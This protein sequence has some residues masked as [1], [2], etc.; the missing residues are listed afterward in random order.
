M[1]EGQSSD[2]VNQDMGAQSGLVD[3]ESDEVGMKCTRR[4]GV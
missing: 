4:E 1:V 3:R 2:R